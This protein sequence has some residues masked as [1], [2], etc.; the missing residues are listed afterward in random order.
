MTES[1]KIQ[2]SP[3]TMDP[4][5]AT[6]WW[7]LYPLK[8]LEVLDKEPDLNS[9]LFGDFSVVSK[10]HISS[11]V[12]RLNLNDRMAPGHDHES[13]VKYILSRIT[14]DEEFQSYIAVRRTGKVGQ[15]DARRALERKAAERA[16]EVAGLLALVFLCSNPE[17]Q[18]CGLVE[19]LQRRHTS[20][21]M[22]DL[23]AG[24]FS[25]TFGYGGGGDHMILDRRKNIKVRRS[26]LRRMFAQKR[27][28]GLSAMVLRGKTGVHASLVRIAVAAL[29]ALADAMHAPSPATSLLG[30]VT[31]ME[32]VLVNQG[33]SFDLLK[34]RLIALV[35]H[36]TA[37]RYDIDAVL[38]SRH[39]FVH[40]GEQ[41]V[42]RGIPLK[43]LGLGMS[44]LLN[45]ASIAPSFNNKN[46]MAQYLEFVAS[47]NRTRHLWARAQRIRFTELLVHKPLALRL[48]AVR[49]T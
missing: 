20:V 49:T 40:K 14:G 42:G 47:G 44:C 9:P 2:P 16:R 38:Q 31:S 1:K 26:D 24:A 48:P 13:D 3:P 34:R 22:F 43:G 28:S 37:S 6:T 7:A 46:D 19:T 11:L 45:F 21:A 23:A 33:D 30:A 10:R 17:W 39:R 27:F 32:L 41:P 4:P 5:R 15:R 25:V 29:G 35:G 12:N 8:G 36:T 18:T